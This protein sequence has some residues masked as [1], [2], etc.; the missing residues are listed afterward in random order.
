VRPA[1][2]RPFTAWQR[3]RGSLGSA[4]RACPATG[5]R[6]CSVCGALLP[7]AG[8][9][10]HSREEPP[11]ARCG[12]LRRT[13]RCAAVQGEGMPYRVIHLPTCSAPLFISPISFLSSL[14]RGLFVCC[15]WFLGFCTHD[16]RYAHTHD[17]AI[18]RDIAIWRILFATPLFL[19]FNR[20]RFLTLRLPHTRSVTLLN[21]WCTLHTHG[22]HTLLGAL[23]LDLMDIYTVP[24]C[25]LFRS[26]VLFSYPHLV[27]QALLLSDM[28]LH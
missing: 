18:S 20:A 5:R 25:C 22:P 14:V 15:G 16:G 17:F 6:L 8:G 13:Q 4:G 3:K 11:G 27:P 10:R 21:I 23:E 24:R 7:S 12:G 9:R 28:V 2:Q 26:Q 19:E 1:G